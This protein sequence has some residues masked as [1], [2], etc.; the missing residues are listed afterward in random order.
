MLLPW[1]RECCDK[2]SDDLGSKICRNIVLCKMWY[3]NYF[4]FLPPVPAHSQSSFGSADHRSEGHGGLIYFSF[5][6][7]MIFI[8]IVNWFNKS[9]EQRLH[10]FLGQGPSLRSSYINNHLCRLKTILPV[11]SPVLQ[12]PRPVCPV[13]VWCC[14]SDVELWG[15]LATYLWSLV[16]LSTIMGWSSMGT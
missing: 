14:V 11:M 7:I 2:T 5:P 4:N 8:Q 1:W 13:T 6:I 3:Q 12:W 15:D 10:L 16:W 9:V